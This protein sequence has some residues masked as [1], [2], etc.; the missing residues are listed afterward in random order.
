MKKIIL[1]FML[2]ISLAEAKN[3]KVY[4]KIEQAC[5]QYDHTT[6]SD[7]KKIFKSES[8]YHATFNEALF[9]TMLDFDSISSL[10]VTN[11]KGKAI[12]IVRT[13]K[14]KSIMKKCFKDDDKQAINFTK[15]YILINRL[16]QIAGVSTGLISSFALIR[17]LK[18]TYGAL[19]PLAK[20]AF[21]LS[22]IAGIIYSIHSLY[23][24]I[25]PYKKPLN[26]LEFTEINGQYDQQLDSFTDE[27]IRDAY[28]KISKLEDEKMH[29]TDSHE[30][31]ENEQRI[32]KIRDLIRLIK[33]QTKEIT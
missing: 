22:S 33:Q 6:S 5:S 17:L 27:A 1:F 4:E 21:V 28:K 16:S 3:V 15:H 12:N 31:I 30:L 32:K 19:S 29:L 14:Y 8:V 18:K 2:T 26:Q 7:L 23:K 10:I 25:D 24:I 13:D 9:A 11:G 20:K